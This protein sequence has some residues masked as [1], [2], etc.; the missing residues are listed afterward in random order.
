MTYTRQA[1]E[2]ILQMTVE[3]YQQ[4]LMMLGA[5]LSTTRPP[6]LWDWVQF[7]N[8]LNRTN[9]EFTP[10]AVGISPK[11]PEMRPLRPT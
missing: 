10:Y 7:V 3:D 8:D 11:G 9:P 6:I 5:G 4:L 1:N 2:V